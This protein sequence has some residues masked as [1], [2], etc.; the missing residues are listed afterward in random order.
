MGVGRRVPVDH[1]SLRL[2]TVGPGSV[3]ARRRLE[4]DRVATANRYNATTNIWASI[5]PVPVA[6]E[7]P[8]AALLNGKIYLA[9]GDTRRLVQHLR[10]RDEHVVGRALRGLGMRTTTAPRPERS[11]ARC[12]SSAGDS[13]ATDTTSIYTVA[14]NS[15]T[16]GPSR[17]GAV[18]PRGLYD[19]WPVP[20]RRRRLQLGEPDG[21]RRCDDAARH[22]DRELVARADVH[23]RASRRGRSRP[24]VTRSTPLAATRTEAGSSTRR[25]LST[26]STSAPGRAA[27]GPRSR[28]RFRARARATRPASSRPAGSAVRCGRPAGSTVRRSSS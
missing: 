3:R 20:L 12:T 26:R 25:R 5:A 27:R 11:A 8:A 19:R 15:W 1:H 2:R 6:S 16:T 9:E 28:I 24:R 23:A 13:G 18:L 7:A 21:E 4:R 10:H 22:G 14:T 17:A